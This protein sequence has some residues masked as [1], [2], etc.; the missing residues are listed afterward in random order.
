MQLNRFEGK[1]GTF[2]KYDRDS[3]SKNNND[4]CNR[5]RKREYISKSLNCVKR[6]SKDPC[7]Q[8]IGPRPETSKWKHFGTDTI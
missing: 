5:K 4:A 6:V 3:R 2:D 1:I 7:D 8:V